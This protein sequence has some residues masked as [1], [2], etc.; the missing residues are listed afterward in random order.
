[1]LSAPDKGRT[2][3][4]AAQTAFHS[5]ASQVLLDAVA[6]LGMSVTLRIS[7]TYGFHLTLAVLQLPRAV[8][9]VLA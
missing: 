1:M 4:A 2:R 5:A 3:L 7:L 6:P 9:M 8:L